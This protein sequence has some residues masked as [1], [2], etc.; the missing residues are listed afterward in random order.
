M[1]CTYKDED[2]C[3]ERFQ[4]YEDA[5]GKSIL[6]VVKE[7]GKNHTHT[8][9]FED[10][11]CVHKMLN[12]IF[13][14]AKLPILAEVCLNKKNLWLLLFYLPNVKVTTR[15]YNHKPTHPGP[16]SFGASCSI[17]APF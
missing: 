16:L 6:F 17:S 8:H 7:P 10:I 13:Q 14:N 4:Y 3:V 1:N 9:I 5:S 15:H 2:D 12:G 11:F